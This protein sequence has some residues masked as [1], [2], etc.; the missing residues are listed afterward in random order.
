MASVR[1]SLCMIVRDEGGMIDACLASVKGLVSEV[2]VVDTG[3]KDDTRERARRAGAKVFDAPWRDDFAWARNESLSHATGDWVLVLD[4]DERLVRCDFRAIRQMLARTVADCV[5]VR[6]HDADALAATAEEVVSGLR[7]QGDP[8]RL[9]RFARR[10]P[11]LAYVGVIHEDLG[12]WVVKHG[13]KV[14]AMDVDI[15]HYGATKEIDQSRGKFERNVRLLTELARRSPEDPTALGYLAHQYLGNGRFPEAHRATEE[16]WRRL[17]HVETARDYTRSVLR[18]AQARV[19]LQLRCGDAKGALETASRARRI[20]GRHHDLDYI[21]GYALEALGT[22]ER[23]PASRS[24]LLFSARASFETCLASAGQVYLQAFIEGATG[25][26]AW[27]RLGVIALLLGDPERAREAFG[28]ALEKRPALLESRLGLLEA[29]IGLGLLDEALRRVG[30]LLEDAGARATPDLWVLAATACEAGGAIDDMAKML[31]QARAAKAEYT[32]T[33]RRLMHA[34]RVAA[35]AMYRGKPVGG[36]G[37]VGVLGALVARAGVPPA[38]VGAWPSLLPTVRTVLRNLAQL[39]MLE[40]IEPLFEPRADVVV[41]GLTQHVEQAARELRLDLVYQAPGEG[42]QVRGSDA[43]FITELL[44]A[45]PRLRGRVH[46]ATPDDGLAGRVVVAGD[47]DAGGVLRIT[48]KELLED[49]VL[50]CDRLLAALG[51]GDASSLVRH[52]VERYPIAGEAL[53]AE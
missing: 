5:M 29:T 38:D 2:I 3:S 18:L 14:A 24:K 26:A 28:A 52:V 45:H 31:A 16:G 47:S 33:H 7:R 11:D 9:P 6:L 51:E 40:Q 48:Q 15:V 12:P 19:Q 25:W 43:N 10:K 34:E 21:S 39:G 23:D 17:R 20:E 13:R 46:Q 42:I 1:I 35:L 30:E 36:P 50:H 41:P 27:N 37:L 49:P 8:Q 22:I 44:A 4:A 53:A 32:S